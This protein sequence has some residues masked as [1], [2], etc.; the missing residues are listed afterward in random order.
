MDVIILAGGKGSRL[1]KVINDKPKVLSDISGTPF[2]KYLVDYIIQTSDFTRLVLATGYLSE[3]VE[4]FMALNYPGIPYVI[5]RETTPLGT[6]GAIKQ[7]LN[8]CTTSDVLVMNGDT[9]LKINI[10]EFY[11]VHSITK[12]DCTLVLK[13]MEKYDRYGT[14]T[15]KDN[16]RIVRFE[17][18]KYQ[19][20]GLINAGAFLLKKAS[21]EKLNLPDKFSIESD[22]FEKYIDDLTFNGYVTDQYFIDIGIPDDYFKA[23]IELSNIIN[24]L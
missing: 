19:E 8:F 17:E 22:F 15:I 16:D 7:A 1:K 9:F 12:A 14:V 5:S 2:L 3:Q 24:T 21:F 4:E 13:Q 11:K 18:K 23:Q 6:G 20:S 10:Q